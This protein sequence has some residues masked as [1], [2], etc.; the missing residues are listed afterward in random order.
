M[1]DLP[2]S[3]PAELEPAFLAAFDPPGKLVA[4]IDALGPTKD[5][6]VLVV[7]AARGPIVDGLRK[8]DAR[9]VTL[10]EGLERGDVQ[11]WMLNFVQKRRLIMHTD[12]A[13]RACGSSSSST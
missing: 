13:L 6:D 1:S 11:P 7:D 4:T 8:S 3:L 5:R 2:V 9:I 10:I 12:A